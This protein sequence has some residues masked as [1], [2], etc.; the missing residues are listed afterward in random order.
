MSVNLIAGTI[1]LVQKHLPAKGGVYNC[2][3]VL[4]AF[5]ALRK[6]SLRRTCKRVGI[7]RFL[8]KSP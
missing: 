8:I 2:A 3:R 7:D 5:W 6:G 4:I 1:A